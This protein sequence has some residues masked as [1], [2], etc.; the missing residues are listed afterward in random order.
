MYHSGETEDATLVLERL[1]REHPGRKLGAWGF[2]LGGNVLLKLMGERSDGGASLMD[3]TVAMSV[4]FDLSA[5]GTHLERT[6]MGKLYTAYFLRS[7]R[8]KVRAKVELLQAHVDVSAALRARTLRE[9]DDAATA[10]LHG[11]RDAEQYYDQCS[12]VRYL[13]GVRVPTLI[14]QSLDDP[15]LPPGTVPV[16]AMRENPSF[17]TVLT[18]RGGH[19]G[20]IEGSP[21]RPRLWGEETGASFLAEALGA[22]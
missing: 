1:R 19:V 22:V 17:T 15:F 14:L 20:F 2:S 8:R 18:E 7:L 16:V 12:G 21:P 13:A 10:P 5:G 9:F 11:F 4:P 6:R 3:A